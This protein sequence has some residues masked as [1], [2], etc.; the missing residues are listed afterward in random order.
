MFTAHPHRSL[1][2][3]GRLAVAGALLGLL[4][5]APGAHAQIT[6]QEVTLHGGEFSF[7]PST[8]ELT[9]GV[10]VKLTVINDGLLDHDM[11]STLPLSNLS[12]IQADN[13]GDE[14]QAN[15]ASGSLDID[16]LKGHSSQVVF[17]PTQAGTFDFVCDI[18]G[19]TEAGMKGTFVV[20]AA[21]S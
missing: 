12:Y 8:V 6:A 2:Q 19:H 10:P 16:Y 14:Q 9:V 18:T 7:A 4:G 13:P 11:K 1:V 5:L 17:T 15:A 21:Q 3:S 20:K